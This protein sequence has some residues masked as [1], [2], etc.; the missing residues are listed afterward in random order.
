MFDR[1]ISLKFVEIVSLLHFCYTFDETRIVYYCLNQLFEQWSESQLLI[2]DLA[3]ILCVPFSVNIIIHCIR[4]VREVHVTTTFII[5]I[6]KTCG[7]KH[8]IT[9]KRKKKCSLSLVYIHRLVIDCLRERGISQ[10][11]HRSVVTIN[12]GRWSTCTMPYACTNG[13][14]VRKI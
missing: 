12:N 14:C 10:C 13:F 2:A 7:R 9:I 3:I 6:K 5:P 1:W 4:S 8:Q 11:S